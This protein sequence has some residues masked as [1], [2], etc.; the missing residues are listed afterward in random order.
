[1]IKNF[2]KKTVTLTIDLDLNQNIN[3]K[4]HDHYVQKGDMRWKDTKQIK[5]TTIVI[6]VQN[7]KLEVPTFIAVIKAVAKAP[8]TEYVENVTKEYKNMT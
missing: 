1:M 6:Y 4:I 8:K 3:P 2:R 7:L 5:A